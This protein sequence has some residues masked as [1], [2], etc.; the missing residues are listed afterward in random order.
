ML[1]LIHEQ[2]A[3]DDL[4]VSHGDNPRLQIPNYVMSSNSRAAFLSIGSVSCLL[5]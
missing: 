3:E 1:C 5:K 2:E 4:A